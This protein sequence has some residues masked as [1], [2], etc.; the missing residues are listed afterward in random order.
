MK[1]EI[2][3]WYWRNG[4]KILNLGEHFTP[5][6]VSSLG[7]SPKDYEEA[8]SKNELKSYRS[9]LMIIGSELTKEQIDSLDVPEV[10]IWGQGKGL[11]GKLFDFD[12]NSPPYREKVKIYA[13]RGP[14]TARELGLDPSIP[15]GDPAFLIPFLFPIEKNQDGKVRYVPHHKN[16]KH[17]NEKLKYLGAD[18]FVDVMIER[19]EALKEVRRIVSSKLVL[20]NSLHCSIIAHSYGVPW[21]VSLVGDERLNMPNKWKDFLEF[22]GIHNQ[23]NTVNNEREG[24]QWWED[25]ARK[26]EIPSLLPL[27]RSFPYTMTPERKGLIERLKI[28]RRKI[29]DQR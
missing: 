8:K 15:Q 7:Y 12:L 3:V 22:L 6:L 20:T 4:Q 18:E 19:G 17:I 25:V 29:N 10:H 11:S 13:V 5:I 1:K 28:V 23:F 14:N 2:L 24:Y 16:R 9:C 21:A 26:A 27:V